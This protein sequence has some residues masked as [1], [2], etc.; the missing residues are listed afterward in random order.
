ME[1]NKIRVDAVKLSEKFFKQP[2][3][4]SYNLDNNKSHLPIL[5][6]LSV[7]DVIKK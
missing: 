4:W 5:H 1:Y 2:T 6:Y 3:Y 7:S